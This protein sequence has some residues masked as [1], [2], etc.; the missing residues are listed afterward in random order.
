MESENSIHKRNADNQLFVAYEIPPIIS[1]MCA[2][3]NVNPLDVVT[4]CISTSSS[5][6]G[7]M[8][9]SI[10]DL[11]L[12]LL[13]SYQNIFDMIQSIVVRLL[14]ALKA[15]MSQHVS[16]EDEVLSTQQS[17]FLVDI[18]HGSHQWILHLCVSAC[19]LLDTIL[20]KNL[21][22]N[23]ID[24]PIGNGL[25]DMIPNLSI[26]LSTLCDRQLQHSWI[27]GQMYSDYDDENSENLT[28]NRK[29][30]SHKKITYSSKDIGVLI[31]LHLK[32]ANHP[33]ERVIYFVEEQL[34]DL[35]T[36]DTS[37]VHKLYPTLT[38]SELHD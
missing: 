31:Q 3:S 21:D 33:L 38:S 11:N 1:I 29:A 13:S 6:G 17:S 10:E 26:Q 25:L 4:S 27:S 34:S 2:I 7:G 35:T 36:F 12:L 8:M 20:Q 14:A 24:S 15:A 16:E 30:N 28:R 19:T 5:S 23:V 18:S 22:H 9:Y 37:S 32:W